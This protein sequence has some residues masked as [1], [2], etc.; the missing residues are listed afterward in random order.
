[1]VIFQISN[2]SSFSVVLTKL[3]NFMFKNWIFVETTLRGGNEPTCSL[4][5]L[6]VFRNLLLVILLLM[7]K[8]PNKQIK[9]FET[10]VFAA[11][12]AIFQ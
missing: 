10:F 4:F 6:S 9:Y 2:F 8:E 7:A 12:F 3:C 5:S 1:M 11:P